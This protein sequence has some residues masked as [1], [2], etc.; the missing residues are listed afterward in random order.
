MNV[1]PISYRANSLDYKSNN[2]IDNSDISFQGKPGIVKNVKEA[3]NSR[4]GCLLA[5]VAMVV[6]GIPLLIKNWIKPHEINQPVDNVNKMTNECAY[7][8]I[9]QSIDNI[10]SFYKETQFDMIKNNPCGIMSQYSITVDRVMN[11]YEDNDYT[12]FVKEATHFLVNNCLLSRT[13]GYFNGKYVIF[14]DNMK[15]EAKN[16]K[17]VKFVNTIKLSAQA[18]ISKDAQNIDYD[19]LNKDI[20]D[21]RKIMKL[22]KS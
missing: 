21:A 20:E 3:A 1:S 4:G 13:Y 5:L 2:K 17:F 11:N 14:G 19:S 18:V 16:P 10:Q 8:T 15:K 6:V 9:N 12:K 22:V 7:T